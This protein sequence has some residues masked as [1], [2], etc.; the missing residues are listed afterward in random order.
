MLNVHLKLSKEMEQKL[1]TD[2]KDLE[3]L[4]NKTQDFHTKK[5]ITRYLE[6]ANKTIKYH[7]KKKL[8]KNEQYDI[9]DLLEK[10]NLQ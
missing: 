8:K 6:Y 3:K 1:K 7:N 5:A 4:T 10:L 9:K 2:F